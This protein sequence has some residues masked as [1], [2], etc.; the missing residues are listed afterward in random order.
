MSLNEKKELESAVSLRDADITRLDDEIAV[1]KSELDTLQTG[2]DSIFETKRTVLSRPTTT[3]RGLESLS[4]TAPSVDEVQLSQGVSPIEQLKHDIIELARTNAMKE[5]TLVQLQ[6]D[7]EETRLLMEG[8]QNEKDKMEQ[9]LRERETELQHHE[10]NR[11]TQ[12]LTIKNLTT[13]KSTLQEKLTQSSASNEALLSSI[14]SQKQEKT[15]MQEK[16]TK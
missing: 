4:S 6:K 7:L 11:E 15:T 16:Q 12:E 14:E 3:E 13:D 10:E 5:E 9:Q 1:L 2:L 8:L